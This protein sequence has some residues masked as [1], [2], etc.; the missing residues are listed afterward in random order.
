MSFRLQWVKAHQD[1]NKPFEELPLSVQLNIEADNLAGQVDAVPNHLPTH[2]FPSTE[3][4]LHSSRHGSITSRYR[5]TIMTLSHMESYRLKL[6]DRWGWHTS[7]LDTIDWR[8]FYASRKQCLH[9]QRI[10][11]VTHTKLLNRLLPIA[12]RQHRSDSTRLSKCPSC[13]CPVETDEHLYTCPHPK[14]AAWRSDLQTLLIKKYADN[15]QTDPV[16]ATLLVEGFAKT[17]QDLPLSFPPVPPTYHLLW[18]HQSSIGW[19]GLFCGHVSVEWSRLQHAH[20]VHSPECSRPDG[21]QWVLKLVAT[22]QT[23]WNLLWRLRNESQHGS[24]EDPLT[25]EHARRSQLK[26]EIAQVCAYYDYL[27]PT[28]QQVIQQHN[29]KQDSL[30]TSSLQAWLDVFRPLFKSIAHRSVTATRRGMRTLY[31]YFRPP[32]PEPDKYPP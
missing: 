29:R 5:S 1:D 18:H 20:M 3:V 30:S 17:F 12:Y 24:S 14:R 27:P 13:P 25:L 22:L 9:Q 7:V 23:H 8:V 11:Q 28:Y 10:N 32:L 26:R 19:V 4:V 6:A 15:N 2:I 31:H 16:L 21:H